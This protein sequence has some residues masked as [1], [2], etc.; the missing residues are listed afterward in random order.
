MF[1]LYYY[2]IFFYS[3]TFTRKRVHKHTAYYSHLYIFTKLTQVNIQISFLGT[4]VF[5]ISIVIPKGLVTCLLAVS[6]IPC[7]I[8]CAVT[9]SFGHM[10]PYN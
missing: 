10:S 9:C 7:W 2:K 3:N 1:T 6:V 4:Y 8:C 5:E